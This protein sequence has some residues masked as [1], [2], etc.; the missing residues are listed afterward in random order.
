[1]RLCF[2]TFITAVCFLFLLMTRKVRVRPWVAI[3]F[4][5]YRD[6]LKNR[7]K[8][9]KNGS[10]RLRMWNLPW[11]HAPSQTF[12]KCIPGLW[13][14]AG[15]GI[16]RERS[17]FSALSHARLRLR[18][19]IS[20]V[21]LIVF[22]FSFSFLFFSFFRNGFNILLYGLGSKRVLLDQFRS[23]KLSSYLQIVVNGYF[24]S[25][26]I[27]SVSL[28]FIF[29]WFCNLLAEQ[30]FWTSF[31]LFVTLDIMFRGNLFEQWYY[32]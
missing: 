6:T 9:L 10:N 15:C 7:S 31:L 17:S 4:L 2:L 24:P 1:M 13:I 29:L 26:T 27:K 20:I 30:F 5:F 28:L 11:L 12:F 18:Y 19:V 16:D 21:C 32:H 25:L 22:C 14:R 8:C 23:S 3:F